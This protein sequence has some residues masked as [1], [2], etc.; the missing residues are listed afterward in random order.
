[1]AAQ[2]LVT[3]YPG[4]NVVG[5][6]FVRSGQFF[7]APADPAFVPSRHFRAMNREA[8]DELRKLKAALEAADAAKAEL[9]AR[10]GIKDGFNMPIVPPRLAGDVNLELWEPEKVVRV[11]QDSGLTPDQVAAVAAQ[12]APAEPPAAPPKTS[13]RLADA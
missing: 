6:G 4:A 10:A 5:V 2:F 3:R 7:T 1:M 8:Q 11:V 9:Y 13:K 12:Q